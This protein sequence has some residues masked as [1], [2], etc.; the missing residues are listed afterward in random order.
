MSTIPA[1]NDPHIDHEINYLI[2]KRLNQFH[3][4]LVERGQIAPLSSKQN[5][6][7]QVVELI[8]D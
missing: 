7:P 3:D 4:V 8:P 2:T 6:G 5:Y 1:E